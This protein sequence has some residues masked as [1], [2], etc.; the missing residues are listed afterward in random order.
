MSTV[1]RLGTLPAPR[2]A[3]GLLED[4]ETFLGDN[5]PADDVTLIVVKVL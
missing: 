1:E 5:V 2:I 3:E 4:L